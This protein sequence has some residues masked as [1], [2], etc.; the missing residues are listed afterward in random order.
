M[1]IG[2]AQRHEVRVGNDCGGGREVLYEGACCLTEGKQLAVAIAGYE[3]R[4]FVDN[5]TDWEAKSAGA[6]RN[7]R[8]DMGAGRA[9]ELLDGVIVGADDGEVAIGEEAQAERLGE[10]RIDEDIHEHA[11]GSVEADDTIAVTSDNIEM[12]IGAEDHVGRADEFGTVA[13]EHVHEGAREGVIAKDAIVEL[14]AD[15]EIFATENECDWI[16]EAAG[17]LRNES[18]D[19]RAGLAIV[20]KDCVVV[21]AGDVNIAVGTEGDSVPAV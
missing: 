21:G 11:G 12:A 7:D 17:A 16:I 6:G 14:A 18:A 3:E 4:A 1:R 20:A 13:G 5:A 9:V 15:V 8:T 10:V 2:G 19:E